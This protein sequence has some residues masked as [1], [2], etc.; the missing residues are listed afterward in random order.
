MLKLLFVGL[1]ITAPL[2]T[3]VLRS[4]F[5]LKRLVGVAVTKFVDIRRD[6]A[7]RYRRQCDGS[8]RHR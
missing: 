2:Q 3:Q 7:I 4:T 8:N 5:R 1:L 6:L